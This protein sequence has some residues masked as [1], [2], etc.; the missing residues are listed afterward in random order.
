MCSVQYPQCPLSAQ[1]DQFA[2]T[3]H[4]VTYSPHPLPQP[5]VSSRLPS[6]PGPVPTVPAVRQVK[7]SSYFSTSEL[8]RTSISGRG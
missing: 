1:T 5:C 8:C 6:G 4:T 3:G 7:L 2:V